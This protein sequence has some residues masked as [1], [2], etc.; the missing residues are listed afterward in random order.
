ME[1]SKPFWASK[2]LWVNVLALAAV[3]A[4]VFGVESVATFL[5][6]EGQATVVATIMSIVNIVLRLTTSTKVTVK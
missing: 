2:T 4:G 1:E 5:N 3:L 6:A